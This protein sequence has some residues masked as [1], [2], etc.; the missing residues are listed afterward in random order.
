MGLMTWNANSLSVGS[1]E[2]LTLWCA[3]AFSGHILL[4]GHF[5]SRMNTDWLS[6]LQVASCAAIGLATFWWVEAPFVRW[7]PAVV[8]ALVLTS[9]LA[10][11]LAF[12]IQT[13]AQ[14]RTSATRAAVIFS[15]EPVFAWGA[16]WLLAGEML[17]P[18]AVTGAFCILGGILLVELKPARPSQH[19]DS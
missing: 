13:W 1:G 2:I 17:T 19:P 12:W 8:F 5:S 15:L 16:S 7:S 6:L 11:A 18:R 4:L 9:L 10:T 14:A 3:V